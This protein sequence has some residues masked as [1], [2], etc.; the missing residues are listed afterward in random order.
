[1][2]GGKL[3]VNSLLKKSSGEVID[4]NVI[5]KNMGSALESQ[6]TEE[7]TATSLMLAVLM[8]NWQKE[9]KIWA[10]RD[11]EITS[12]IGSVQKNNVV[13]LRKKLIDKK[14]V[15]IQYFFRSDG[16]ERNSSAEI[17]ASKLLFN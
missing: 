13:N 3:V 17:L 1:L 6:I 16:E 11:T 10:L 14:I 7:Q 5:M 9:K 2:S 15:K 8:K 12:L 4:F